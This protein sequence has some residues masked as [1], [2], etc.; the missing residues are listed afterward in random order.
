MNKMQF[1]LIFKALR[2]S[3]YAYFAA[4]SKN[5]DIHAG[6]MSVTPKFESLASGCVL[7][8]IQE[9]SIS[10][11]P[12]EWLNDVENE[13]RKVDARLC[14]FYLSQESHIDEKILLDSGYSKVTEV[15]LA[16]SLSDILNIPHDMTGQ[17]KPIEDHS[18]WKDKKNLYQQTILGPDGHDMQNGS[19]SELEKIKCDTRYMVSYIYWRENLPV[20]AVSLSIQDNFARLKNLLVHPQYRNQGVGWEIVLHLMHEAK[21]KGAKNFGVYAVDNMHSYKLYLKCGMQEILRHVEWSKE[22]C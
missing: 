10:I 21:L 19:F 4:G 12:E 11:C 20:G 16:V 13:F 17:L 9:S 8:N 3:E 1:A 6:T 2:N 18:G 7:Y 22:L 15:G 5:R 14:R